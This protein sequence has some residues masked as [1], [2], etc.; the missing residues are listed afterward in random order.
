MFTNDHI[1]KQYDQDL[2]SIRSRVLLMGSLVENQIRAAIVAFSEGDTEKAT[3]VDIEDHR[4]NALEVAIDL[5][6][7]QIVVRRQPAA[8]D[9]RMLMGISKIVTDLERSGDEAAKIARMTRTIYSR[10]I[11]RTS[12]IND[13]RDMGNL[14]VS[15]LRAALDTFIRQDAARAADIVRDDLEIDGKFKAITRQLIT[16]M[17]E[18]PRLISTAMEIMCIAK[19]MERIGDHAKNLAEQVIYIVRGTDVR[20][21][22]IEQLERE[23]KG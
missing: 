19:S 23:A 4:I 7:T 8:I 16:F 6:C 10:D 12:C 9:L 1:A 13:V 21:V 22:A 3:Q 18:D 17:M 14:A 15:L 20:H 11:C 2:D 5:D